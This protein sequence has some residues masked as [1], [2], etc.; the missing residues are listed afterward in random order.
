MGW[1]LRRK[2][3]LR[4][5]KV[6]ERCHENGKVE[7][8]GIGLAIVQ[9]AAERMNGTVGVESMPGQGSKFWIQL[10]SP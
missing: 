3:I 1:A 4:I 5:F 2:T 9:R 8:S 10:G 6:F 7:G